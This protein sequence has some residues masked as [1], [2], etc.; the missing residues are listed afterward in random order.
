MIAYGERHMIR[1]GTEFHINPFFL[2]YVGMQ[3]GDLIFDF[4]LPLAQ[5]KNNNENLLGKAMHP[6]L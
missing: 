1:M 6:I 3:S 2:E 5:G 4:L